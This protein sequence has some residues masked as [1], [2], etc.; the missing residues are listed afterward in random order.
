MAIPNLVKLAKPLKWMAACAVLV[1]G[2]EGLSTTT[3]HDKLANGLPTVCYGETI[4]VHMGDH[5]TKQQCLDML[6]KRLP[7]YW[8]MIEPS[9]HVELSDNE[10]IAYTSFT[11]NLGPGA[12]LHGSILKKL[13]AMDHVGACRAM[14]LYDRTRSMGCVKG[15]DRRR[16]AEERVCLTVGQPGP[17]QLVVALCPHDYAITPTA[18]PLTAPKVLPRAISKPKPAQVCTQ[19]LFW[20]TCK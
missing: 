13:N 20:R 16:H 15:L 3:Y 12:F 8:A 17:P 9:I 7:E 19:F 14:L 2:F 18:A 11:Y 6:A 10:K 4:G 1:G 5:Y